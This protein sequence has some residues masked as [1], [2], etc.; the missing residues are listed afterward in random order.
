MFAV[1]VRWLRRTFKKLELTVFGVGVG[2][3][4]RDDAPE[5]GLPSKPDSIP[6]KAPA[7]PVPTVE[8]ASRRTC[9][10]RWLL[11]GGAR[12]CAGNNA[13]DDRRVACR[14]MAAILVRTVPHKPPPPP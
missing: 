4:L 9:S 11:P 5:A 7:E 14:P 6:D 10:M 3:E 1:V 8:A 12:L 2:V 13:H